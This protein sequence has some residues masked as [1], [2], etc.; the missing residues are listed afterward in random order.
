MAL[1]VLHNDFVFDTFE[2]CTYY[3]CESLHGYLTTDQNSLNVIHMNIR[4]CNRNFDEFAI[5]INQTGV[6]F[7]VIVLTETWLTA[8]S[9]WLN[10]LG[11]RAFHSIRGARAGGGVTILVSD[12][13]NSDKK[14][15]LCRNS[16]SAEILAVEVDVGTESFT[17]FGV[18]RPPLGSVFFV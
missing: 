8:E 17:I 4:S 18:Y 3:D 7:P 5:F 15:N 11:Y 6:E 13:L 10:I 12:R 16:A 14:D 2:Q 1:N 9:D